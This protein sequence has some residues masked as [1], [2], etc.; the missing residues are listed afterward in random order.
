[1]K[2][3]DLVKFSFSVKLSSSLKQNKH[4]AFIISY[5]K[6]ASLLGCKW[7]QKQKMGMFENCLPEINFPSSSGGCSWTQG[8]VCHV[9]YWRNAHTSTGWVFSVGGR[10]SLRNKFGAFLQGKYI[11]YALFCVYASMFTVLVILTIILTIKIHFHSD[12]IRIKALYYRKFSKFPPNSQ[13]E[14][15]LWSSSPHHTRIA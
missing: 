9:I 3:N 12:L 10:V 1:M 6:M 15:K 13:A 11:F 8:L 2:Y 4:C 14:N 5:S 7:K